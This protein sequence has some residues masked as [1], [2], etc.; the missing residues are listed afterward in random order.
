M[1]Q[2]SKRIRVWYSVVESREKVKRY[3]TE[4][5]I[6]DSLLLDSFEISVLITDF[7]LIDQLLLSGN[8]GDFVIAKALIENGR[9]TEDKT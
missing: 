2:D 1:D 3:Y 4:E 9:R 6:N 8:F 7:S 5:L